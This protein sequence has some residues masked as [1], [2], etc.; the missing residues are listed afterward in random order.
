MDNQSGILANIISKAIE[1]AFFEFAWQQ[2]YDQT[3]YQKP[4]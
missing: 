2:R 1:G 3:Y 4:R